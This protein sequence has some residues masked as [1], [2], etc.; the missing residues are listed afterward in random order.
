M[1]EPDCGTSVF[2]PSAIHPSALGPDENEAAEA[3]AIEQQVIVYYVWPGS[4]Y[5]ISNYLL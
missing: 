1:E 4:T 2:N 5:N 3:R